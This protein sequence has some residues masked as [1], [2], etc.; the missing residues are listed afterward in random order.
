LDGAGLPSFSQSLT[1]FY[2]GL[3]VLRDQV[4]DTGSRPLVAL[5]AARLFP[6]RASWVFINRAQAI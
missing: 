4:P 1:T 2:N 3:S 6:A 5:Q